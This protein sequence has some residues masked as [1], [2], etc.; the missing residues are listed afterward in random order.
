MQPSD[1][2]AGAGALLQYI[3][4]ARGVIA[5]AEW[6]ARASERSP[7]EHGAWPARA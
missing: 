1:A 6:Q 2:V 7:I 4:E 3:E 5:E